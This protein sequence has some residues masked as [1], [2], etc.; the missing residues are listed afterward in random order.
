QWDKPLTSKVTSY[1]EDAKEFVPFKLKEVESA[2]LINKNNIKT[3]EWVEAASDEEEA[4]PDT[5]HRQEVTITF[6]DNSMLSGTLVSDTPRELSRLSDCLNTK[7]SFIHITN[8]ER[9][10][11]VNK[12][13][14]L[15]VTGS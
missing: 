15:R 8:G 5:S 9:H 7:E 11:H 12:N 2:E 14:L 10:I 13:M 6:I 1:L 4:L 3:V